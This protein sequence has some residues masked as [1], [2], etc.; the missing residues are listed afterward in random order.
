MRVRDV[1]KTVAGSL[2]VYVV[3]AACGASDRAASVVV[4]GGGA[5]DVA[6]VIVSEIVNPVA[7]AKAEPLPLDIAI[8][9]CDKTY[10]CPGIGTGTCYLAE[11]LYP[12]VK[13]TDLASSV[14]SML[15]AAPASSPLGYDTA[16]VVSGW[17]R[18]GAVA[19][20]CSKDTTVTFVRRR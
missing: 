18:D 12:G 10:P 6:D 7:D 15:E 16:Y 17:V 19:V 14:T 5:E 1:A 8:E 3:A 11:H 13:K 2:F 9:Q 20:G 4:D